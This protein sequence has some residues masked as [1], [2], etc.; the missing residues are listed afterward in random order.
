MD[1]LID[2]AKGYLGD[3]DQQQGRNILLKT[4]LDQNDG[5]R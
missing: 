2:A 1:K 4:N 5:S 3:K